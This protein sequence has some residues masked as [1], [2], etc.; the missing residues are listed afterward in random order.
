MK[1]HG[2]APRKR[3][4]KNLRIQPP[5]PR[6]TLKRV[7]DRDTTNL[8]SPN[9]RSLLR[10]PDKP[11]PAHQGQACDEDKRVRGRLGSFDRQHIGQRLAYI[12]IAEVLFI[13]GSLAISHPPCGGY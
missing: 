4:K 6:A 9:Q 8:T 1:I 13:V 12:K 7:R 2:S 11:A 10:G 3:R 5:A